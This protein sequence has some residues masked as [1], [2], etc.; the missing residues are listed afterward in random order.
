MEEKKL[1][2]TKWAEEDRPR[3]KMLAQ[4]RKALS[5]SELIGIL[6]GSGTTKISAIA[7]AQNLLDES[8]NSLVTL[9]KRDISELKKVKGV[10][11]AKA[12]TIMAALELGSRMWAETKNSAEVFIK[13][14]TSIYN[15]I[16][17]KINELPYEEFW[18]MYLSNSHKLLDCKRISI[19]G[20]T[21]T[22]VDVR[23]ILKSALEKNSTFIALAHNHPSG[24]VRPSKEDIALTKKIQEAC[25][26]MDIKVLDHVI[27]G[28]HFSSGD[29]NYYSFFDN[30]NL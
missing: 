8:G 22:T 21:A 3:E 28:E 6:L 18:V 10:G 20:I 14:S 9:S 24:S 12:V 1:P 25:Q 7:V 23:V 29:C 13:D 30:G 17:H 15:V 2:I 27:V 4:G 5:N 26:I 16:A 11:D 19:G